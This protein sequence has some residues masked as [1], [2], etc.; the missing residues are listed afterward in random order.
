MSGF[1]LT[2]AAFPVWD[3][4]HECT[5]WEKLNAWAGERSLDM[6][7]IPVHPELFV[8]PSPPLVQCLSIQ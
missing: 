6:S 1:E 2:F 4:T 3:V 8:H 7:N 5:N